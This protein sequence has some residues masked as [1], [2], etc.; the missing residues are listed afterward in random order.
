MH[1]YGSELFDNAPDVDVLCDRKN[2]WEHRK[3]EQQ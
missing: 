2:V 1:W 3:K